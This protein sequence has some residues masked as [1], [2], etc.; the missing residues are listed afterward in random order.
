M[1]EVTNS[2]L[3]SIKRLLGIPEGDPTFDADLI[4]IINAQLANLIQMGVG[5]QEGFVI[6]DNTTTWFDFLGDNVYKQTQAQ[7]YVFAKTKITFDSN[8]L[9][10]TAVASYE[11]IAEECGYRLYTSAGQY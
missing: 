4:V 5:P 8:N 6:N 2:I 9:S 11:K 1:E 7:L 10:S 3:A